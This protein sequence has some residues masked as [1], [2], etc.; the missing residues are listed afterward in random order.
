M[1]QAEETRILI[2]RAVEMADQI[3]DRNAREELLNG[4]SRLTKALKEDHTDQ[5]RS[6]EEEL[7]S[8]MIDLEEDE[9]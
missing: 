9:D 5:A 1:W 8:L 6:L 4:V 2:Q 7:L 3:K